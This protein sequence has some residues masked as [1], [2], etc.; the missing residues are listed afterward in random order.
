VLISFYCKGRVFFSSKNDLIHLMKIKM[1]QKLY[2]TSIE[3]TQT[4]RKK[5]TEVFI[6]AFFHSISSKNKVKQKTCYCCAWV[7]LA[8]ILSNRRKA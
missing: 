8:S 7:I 3:E 2:V 5:K 1:M 6:L 4:K